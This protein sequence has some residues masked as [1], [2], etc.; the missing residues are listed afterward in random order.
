M[1]PAPDD[2]P[3]LSEFLRQYRPPLP[4]ESPELE[5]EL[6]AAIAATPH[7]MQMPKLRIMPR[8]SPLWLIP[9]VVAAGL[10]GTVISARLFA[11]P[12]NPEFANLETFIEDSYAPVSEQ[13]T[14]DDLFWL[15]EVAWND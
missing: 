13:S 10:V 1:K 12:S 4:P 14:D 7:E 11:P 9:P 2:D 6:M 5:E 3:R 15:E 8:R